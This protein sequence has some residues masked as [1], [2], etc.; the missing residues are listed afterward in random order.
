MYQREPRDR[1]APT[2]L[3]KRAF[4]VTGFALMSFD[5]SFMKQNNDFDHY[6]CI[7]E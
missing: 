4:G 7:A 2:R 6:V 1:T 5:T 3:R